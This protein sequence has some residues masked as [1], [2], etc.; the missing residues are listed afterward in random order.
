MSIWA[1]QRHKERWEDTEIYWHLDF[2][3]SEWWQGCKVEFVPA[4][5]GYLCGWTGQ[6][7]ND[8]KK[9]LKEKT[10]TDVDNDR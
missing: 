5:I 10:L 8:L 4:I 2:W 9:L 1:K 3:N 7:I 6:Q